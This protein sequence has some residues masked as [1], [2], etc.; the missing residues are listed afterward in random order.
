VFTDDSG[1]KAEMVGRA[2]MY[3]REENTIFLNPDHTRYQSD[4]ELLYRDVGPD[5]ERRKLAKKVFDEEYKFNA[6]VFVVL[7]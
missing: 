6:G 4:L 7:S 3:R 1:L 2:A 5:A